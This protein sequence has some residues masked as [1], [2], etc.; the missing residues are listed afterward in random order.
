MAYSAYGFKTLSH[1]GSVAGAAGTNNAL[2]VYVTNDDAAAVETSGYFNSIASRIKTG[3]V[4]I[5][6]LDKDGDPACR[7]YVMINTSGTITVTA[8][9]ATAIE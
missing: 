1:I 2:H 3:D 4:L 9:Q 7:V 8:S 5:A 6:S